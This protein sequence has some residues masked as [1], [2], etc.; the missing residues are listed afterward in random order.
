MVQSLR[1][2]L[3][4]R[5]RHLRVIINTEIFDSPITYLD[6]LQEF[7]RPPLTGGP[8]YTPWHLRFLQ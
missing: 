1:H 6:D 4:S 3:Q 2:L 7:A 5:V 8:K